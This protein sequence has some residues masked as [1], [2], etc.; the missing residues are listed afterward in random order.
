L[1][2]F[3]KMKGY[4]ILTKSVDPTVIKAHSQI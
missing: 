1:F 4:F 2:L 3:L